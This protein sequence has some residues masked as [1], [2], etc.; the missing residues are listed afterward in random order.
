MKKISVKKYAQA[1][2]EITKDLPKN[3][4]DS[5]IGR[6]LNLVYKYRDFKK[7][8]KIL[9]AYNDI[10]KKEDGIIDALIISADKLDEKQKQYI[11]EHIKKEQKAKVV[12]LEEEKDEALL[13][14]FILK[15]GDIIFDASLKTRLEELRLDM[16]KS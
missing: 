14:G 9:N 10:A 13:G 15:I 16:K 6:F 4:L 8:D 12:N 1:L 11:K 2:Y 5:E 7:I 3:K